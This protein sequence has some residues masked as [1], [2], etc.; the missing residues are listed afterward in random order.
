MLDLLV[1]SSNPKDQEVAKK[2]GVFF[3]N[4]KGRGAHINISGGGVVKWSKIQANAVK[5]LEFLTG[6][7]AQEQFPCDNI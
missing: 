6:P 4:Q 2:V 1:N 5:L 3:P 7:E